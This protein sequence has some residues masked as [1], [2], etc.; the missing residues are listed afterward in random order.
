MRA[1]R[2]FL[3]AVLFFAVAAGPI[4]VAA[5][6]PVQQHCPVRG[7]QQVDIVNGSVN[8]DQAYQVVDAYSPQGDKYQDIQG[9][10]CYSGNAMTMPTVLSCV[11]GNADFAVN[12]IAPP[13]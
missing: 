9:F 6:D 4:G 3:P 1:S 10:T 11:S 13:Q 7:A 2:V 5:A 8:C 12:Q